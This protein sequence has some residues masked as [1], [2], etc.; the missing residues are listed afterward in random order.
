MLAKAVL[1]LQSLQF[2]QYPAVSVSTSSET[3]CE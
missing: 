2:G 1:V 3:F